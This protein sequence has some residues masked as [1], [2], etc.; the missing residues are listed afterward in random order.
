MG[1]ID[2]IGP[3]PVAVDTSLFIYL[4]EEHPVYHSVV[5]PVF[6]SAEHGERD[7]VTS[8][9]T[10]GEVLVLP[11]RA[12]RP[13]LAGRYERIFTHNGSLRL[14]EIDRGQLRAAAQF[15]AHYR[16]RLPDALQLA[17]AYTRRCVAF[18]TNDRRLP[19][20]PGMRIMQLS[21]HI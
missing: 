20:I 8:A 3:G 1:L 18:I 19:G 17:A 4:I 16:V 11:Y 6:A 5:L 13:D 12:G 10:L 9:I 7:L 21:D 2:E 14:V 15:R